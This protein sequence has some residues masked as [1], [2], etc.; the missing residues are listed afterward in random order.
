MNRKYFMTPAVRDGEQI[1]VAQSYS[2]TTGYDDRRENELRINA[3]PKNEN[4][5]GWFEMTVYKHGEK[6]TN[7][8][9]ITLERAQ[10]EAMRDLLIAAFGPG[11]AVKPENGSIYL[12]RGERRVA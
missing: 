8:Q 11:Q 12:P 3:C 4:N 9:S 5:N 2:N 6:R 7:Q 1:H 10:A